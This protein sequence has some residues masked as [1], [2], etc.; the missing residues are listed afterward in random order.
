MFVLHL[1]RICFCF[2]SIV[3]TGD[4]HGVWRDV[5][6]HVIYDTKTAPTM[7]ENPA[8]GNR[9]ASQV[10][11]RDFDAPVNEDDYYIQRLTSYLQV[12]PSLH[13]C[14]CLIINNSGN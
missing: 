3:E 8:F 4:A 10:I 2:F 9:I 5:W 6:N 1:L 14:T 7:R 11:I 13:K 12:N